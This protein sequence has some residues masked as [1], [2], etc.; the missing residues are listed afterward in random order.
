[1]KLLSKL[2]RYPGWESTKC[3]FVLST[4]RTG[5]T[6]VVQLID[7]SPNI[8][9]VHEPEPRHLE[10][11][12]ES[13]LRPFNEFQ[14]QIPLI[15]RARRSLIGKTGAQDLAYAEATIL[16]FFAPTLAQLLP[17]A[18]FLHLY[19]HP[20]DVVR[21]GMRRR[22]YDGHSYDQYKILPSPSGPVA[23][24]WDSWGAFEKNCWTWQAEN[25]YF[26]RFG[27]LVGDD[28]CLK[29]SF[30]D[31]MQPKTEAYTQIFEMLEI[32]PPA[33]GDVEGVLGTRFNEQTD[34]EFPRLSEWSDE[35]KTTLKR[36]AGP[37]IQSLG[38][39]V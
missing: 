20:A 21:S 24:E 7:L 35:Q 17:N 4:G 1:M 11:L 16:K 25:D 18:K 14:S 33:I 19:R 8:S 12:R 3:L 13:F 23:A 38:Y 36:I 34:G 29:M 30:E 31:L 32:E 28:R 10:L 39:Q 27:E 26:F 15:T 6:T 22:W 2:L 5:T 37:A 9:A